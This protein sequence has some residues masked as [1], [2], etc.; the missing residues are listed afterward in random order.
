M[1][2]LEASIR[3]IKSGS[4]KLEEVDENGNPIDVKEREKRIKKEKIGKIIS[5]IIIVLFLVHPTITKIMF[6]AFSCTNI[7]G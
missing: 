7:D 5:S 6:S 2:N 4:Q 3:R 1:D